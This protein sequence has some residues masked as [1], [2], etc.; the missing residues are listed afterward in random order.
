MRPSTDRIPEAAYLDAARA[1]WPEAHPAT[2]EE[3]ARHPANRRAVA[4]IWHAWQEAPPGSDATAEVS[5]TEEER[6]GH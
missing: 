4:A 6:D 1:A 5:S 2:H 3:I